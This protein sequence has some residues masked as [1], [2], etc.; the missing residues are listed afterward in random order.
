MGK[1]EMNLLRIKDCQA[2]NA[3]QEKRFKHR[4][5]SK[6]QRWKMPFATVCQTAGQLSFQPGLKTT[7]I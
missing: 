2:D 4:N 3:R 7:L 5:K 6:A 1:G